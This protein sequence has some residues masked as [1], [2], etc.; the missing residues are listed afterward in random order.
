MSEQA[1]SEAVSTM[2]DMYRRGVTAME[3]NQELRRELG[4]ANDT[5]EKLRKRYNTLNT[6][7]TNAENAGVLYERENEALREQL[8]SARNQAAE[9]LAASVR[10]LKGRDEQIATGKAANERQSERL[11]EAGA[12]LSKLREEHR[13]AMEDATHRLNSKD[14]YIKRLEA[15]IRTLVNGEEQPEL[16]VGQRCFVLVE[17]TITHDS[18]QSAGFWWV[19]TEFDSIAEHF[20]GVPD[21][22][23]Q[24]RI[25][26]SADDIRVVPSEDSE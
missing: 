25:R 11:H 5:V 17:G 18:A 4:L 8:E 24:H 6:D 2:A 7:L 1:L 10:E 3:L 14:A 9:M 26:V 12:R 22:H 21:G 13:E 16:T 20:A 15:H 19:Q 23:R